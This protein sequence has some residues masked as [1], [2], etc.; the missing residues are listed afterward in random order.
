MGCVLAALSPGY[1]WFAYDYPW[2]PGWRDWGMRRPSPWWYGRAHT[3]PEVV[4]EN[5]VP[6]NADGYFHAINPESGYFGGAPGTSYESNPN[7]MEMLQLRDLEIALGKLAREQRQV[8][9]LVSLEG[10]SYEEVATILGIPI[11]TVRSRLSRGRDQLRKLMGVEDD[12]SLAVA[13]TDRDGVEQ[14]DGARRY[15]A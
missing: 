7:A 11:G 3:P 13:N 5:E 10:M 6:L 12:L 15:A 14:R 2:Y 4:S 8:V 9:L 1:W